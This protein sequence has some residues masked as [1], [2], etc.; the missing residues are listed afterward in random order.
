MSLIPIFDDAGN[1]VDALDTKAA[2]V[3]LLAEE[4]DEAACEERYRDVPSK[5]ELHDDPLRI[6]Y[7]HLRTW[8]LF[9]RGSGDY[10]LTSWHRR[11]QNNI[12]AGQAAPA[13][14][15]VK[16]FWDI[17]CQPPDILL[18]ELATRE[19]PASAPKQS[20]YIVVFD[21][22]TQQ[23]RRLDTSAENWGPIENGRDWNSF[24]NCWI[25]TDH[26]TLYRQGQRFVLLTESECALAPLPQRPTCRVLSAQEAADWLLR[27]GFT[28]PNDLAHLASI[29]GVEDVTD[30]EI[31][32]ADERRRNALD[33]RRRQAA[34]A[35]DELWDAMMP[36]AKESPAPQQADPPAAERPQIEPEAV[37][38]DFN[39]RAL[40]FLERHKTKLRDD[41]W[42][43]TDRKAAKEIGCAASRAS[44]L[45]AFK[46]FKERRGPR[47]AGRGKSPH[48]VSLTSPIEATIGEPDEVLERLKKE[49]ERD[50][51]LSPLDDDPPD[52]PTRVKL[53]RRQA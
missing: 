21:E 18:R 19:A 51:E 2:D 34:D 29:R 42:W 52:R 13:C 49:Q 30:D 37:A 36:Q 16:M 39:A 3:E 23:D 33:K 15:M 12:Y 4:L 35:T 38:T 10:V 11:G 40:D 20:T 48:V 43:Y 14:E 1:T 7:A 24:E 31:Q 25:W 44:T 6:S 28:L 17:G 47:P 5:M 53:G 41:P 45:P 8:Q 26:D 9:R 46:A 22:T 27:N 50:F 32:A